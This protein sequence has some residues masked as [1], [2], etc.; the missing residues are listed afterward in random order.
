MGKMKDYEIVEKALRNVTKQA[1]DGLSVGSIEDDARLVIALRQ[2]IW[3]F[4]DR[5][6]DDMTFA[7]RFV[8]EVIEEFNN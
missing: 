1:F 7:I 5:G 8:D 2:T 3:N 4:L 6:D